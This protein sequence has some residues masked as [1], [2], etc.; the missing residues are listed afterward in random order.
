[1][2]KF[3][4]RE[5]AMKDEERVSKRRLQ[6]L[7]QDAQKGEYVADGRGQWKLLAQ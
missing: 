5:D 6:L 2:D 1:M 3:R 4:E 7:L